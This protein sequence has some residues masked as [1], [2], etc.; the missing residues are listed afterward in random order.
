MPALQQGDHLTLSGF[1][2][3]VDTVGDPSLEPT[4]LHPNPHVTSTSSAAAHPAKDNLVTSILKMSFP[5][6]QV[7]KQKGYSVSESGKTI[8]S[9]V[10][11]AGLDEVREEAEI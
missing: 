3:V 10:T 11:K 1:E 6:R 8:S 5:L 2:A 9:S 4:P 7:L